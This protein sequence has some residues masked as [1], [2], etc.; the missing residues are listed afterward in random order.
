MSLLEKWK[1]VRYRARIFDHKLHI[2]TVE[3]PD[4]GQRYISFIVKKKTLGVF[5]EETKLAFMIN[6]SIP[7]KLFGGYI[8]EIDFDIRDS[9][10]LADLLDIAPDLVYDV[11][12]NYR[13]I[14]E[15]KE[16]E[17][18]GPDIEEVLE[19]IKPVTEPEES[20]EKKEPVP[21]PEPK[22]P[23]LIRTTKK[24]MD[25]LGKIKRLPDGAEKNRLIKECLALCLI[26]PDWLNWLPKHL[27]IDQEIHAICSQIK[28]K[29]Y[30]IMPSYYIAHSNAQISEKVLAR[31][32]QKQGWQDV[33]L[34]LG[35]MAIG[36]IGLVV[37]VYF[38]THQVG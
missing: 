14:Q 21:I 20:A 32:P 33:I 10:Q 13:I 15:E 7:P 35:A 27:K 36:V 19:R 34:L 12:E 18:R 6:P 26:H 16:K 29:Q 1:G 31:P 25:T 23:G 8:Q 9:A 17:K 2:A 3:V 24:L 5:G 38:L 22:K 4:R 28:M 37:V 11:N 30:G